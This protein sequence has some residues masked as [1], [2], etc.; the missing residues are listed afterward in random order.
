MDVANHELHHA[1]GDMVTFRVL[2]N[3]RIQSLQATVGG[4]KNLGMRLL[5]CM[6]V[7]KDTAMKH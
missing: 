7:G 3:I 5:R 1:H 2:C 4:V 6:Q